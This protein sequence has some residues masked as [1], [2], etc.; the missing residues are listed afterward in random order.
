MSQQRCL[1]AAKPLASGGSQAAV[2][3]AVS[4]S[5]SYAARCFE[6]PSDEATEQLE[7]RQ[8]DRGRCLGVDTMHSVDP[9]TASRQSASMARCAR[10]CS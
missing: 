2:T 1:Q 5:S 8:S 7:T 4:V 10:A 3:F 6:V 9:K